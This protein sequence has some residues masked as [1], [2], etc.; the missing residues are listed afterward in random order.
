MKPFARKTRPKL[1][2]AASAQRAV[3]C[4]FVVLTQLSELWGLQEVEPELNANSA[5]R[6]PSGGSE[7]QKT[8]RVKGGTRGNKLKRG[9]LHALL[10][11]VFDSALIITLCCVYRQ[12]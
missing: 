8:R 12:K 11:R 10:I 3:Q 2:Q 6:I 1:V 5:P 4:R 7:A 9:R